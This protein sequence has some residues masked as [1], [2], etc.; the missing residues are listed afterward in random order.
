MQINWFV[1]W[2]LLGGDIQFFEA[3]SGRRELKGCDV[4][5]LVFCSIL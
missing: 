1:L 4:E 3:F 5:A 2:L